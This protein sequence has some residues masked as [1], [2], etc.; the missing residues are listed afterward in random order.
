MHVRER[1]RDTERRD[2]VAPNAV[3]AD[4]HTPPTQVHMPNEDAE[5]DARQYEDEKNEV[6]TLA[7]TPAHK[8]AHTC[9]RTHTHVCTHTRS[10]TDTHSRWHTRTRRTRCVRAHMRAHTHAHKHDGTHAHSHTHAHTRWHARARTRAH[11][12]LMHARP[13]S[14]V[15]HGCTQP[16]THAMHHAP[17]V[18]AGGYAGGQGKVHVIKQMNHDGEVNR[19]RY[20]PQVCR[21][22]AWVCGCEVC[23]ARGVRVCA[24]VWCGATHLLVPSS[25]DR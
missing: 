20:M 15:C 17:H 23:E 24:C 21:V 3:D 9:T 19:A 5:L 18:Q 14:R 16:C 1:D 2:D 25:L 8:H 4:K 6:R 12:L 7:R 13:R 11:S 22:C 10:H